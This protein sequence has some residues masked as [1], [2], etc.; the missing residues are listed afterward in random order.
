MMR[1]RPGRSV[2]Q[3]VPSAAKASA[4]G[5]TRP[6][7]T[8]LTVKLRG[9][10]EAS[11][12]AVGVVEGRG[13]GVVAVDEPPNVQPLSTSPARTA[14]PTRWDIVL[15]LAAYDHGTFGHHPMP[16]YAGSRMHQ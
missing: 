13:D 4:Q 5:A 7:A 12:V 3:M 15:M 11:V 2:S 16:K 10:G 1:T 8:D 14:P 6:S 9:C